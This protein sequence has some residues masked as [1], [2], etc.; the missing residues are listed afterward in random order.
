MKA[1][2]LKFVQDPNLVKSL[3]DAQDIIVELIP[4]MDEDIEEHEVLQVLEDLVLVRSSLKHFKRDHEAGRKNY[5]ISNIVQYTS[6][7]KSLKKTQ[8]IIVETLAAISEDRDDS[9]VTRILKNINLIH[10]ILTNIKKELKGGS[11]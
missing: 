6:V 7:L 11:K 8:D 5:S 3:Q 9:D 10:A 1:E 2:L 4:Y